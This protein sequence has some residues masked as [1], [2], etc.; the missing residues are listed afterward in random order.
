LTLPDLN[1]LLKFFI[2]NQTVEYVPIRPVYRNI[3]SK[4]L[5]VGLKLV[6]IVFIMY[7]STM[8]VLES[9]RIVNDYYASTREILSGEFEVETFI[10]N[11]EIVFPGHYDT[12]RWKKI[13]FKNREVNI[14]YMDE[15]AGPWQ[16]NK[17]ADGSKIIIHSNDL[18]STG[19]FS[20]FID[21]D[22]LTLEGTLNQD[23]LKITMRKKGES[24]FL[25]VSR[26]FHW[27]SEYPFSR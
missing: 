9:R 14:Q 17:N 11:G 16:F 10:M 3:Q 6:V 27:V 21:T 25:L 20:A 2:F 7:T 13:Q 12:R 4:Q 22:L 24:S 26:G 1:R 23:S 18:W 5:Y 19:Q 8:Q 15:T